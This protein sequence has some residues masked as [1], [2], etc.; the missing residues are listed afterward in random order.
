MFTDTLQPHRELLHEEYVLVQ[1]WKK[2]ATYIRYHNWFS[3][4]L[5]LDRAAVNLPRFIAD[6]RER[7][8]SPDYWQTEPLR[9]VPAPKTQSWTVRPHSGT[10]APTA[11]GATAAPLR[12]L[13]HVSLADQVVATALMLCLADRVETLQGNPRRKI[14]DDSSRK[15]VVSYG[16]RLF[17]DSI[18]GRLRHRWGSTKLYRSYFE[19]YRAFLKRPERIADTHLEKDH[20]HIV[21][22]HAD[23]RQF[24]DRVRPALLAKAIDRI[25]Q[26]G[27]DPVFFD[28]TKSMLN[29]RWD[30][31]DAKE[32]RAYEKL[33]Q[34][35]DFSQVAL[36]QGLVA[37]GFFANVVLLSFDDELK[38]A[39]GTD[40]APGIKLA[41]A[42]RYV[43]DL[44][45]TVVVV[46]PLVSA[47]PESIGAIVTPW[48]RQLLG[49]H[50]PGLQLSAEKT[51]VDAFG[52]DQPPLVR[53]SSRMTRI[54]T[55]VS[56]GFDAL[57][58]D[59]ILNAIHGLIRAQEAL[60]GSEESGWQLT[61]VPDVRNATVARFAAARF[62]FTFRSI[63]PLLDDDD[64]PEKAATEVAL[65][66]PADPLRIRSR[67]ELDEDA[68]SF[69]LGLIRRWV[70]D[71]SNVRLLRVG[72]DIWPDVQ[73]LG[74]ILSLLR[75]F[76]EKGG[77]RKAPRRVAWYLPFRDPP[78]RSNGNRVCSGRR[79]PASRDRSAR[80]PGDAS[81]RGGTTSAIARCYDSV[82]LAP[83]GSAVPGSR[84]SGGRA[85]HSNWPAQ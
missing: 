32:V 11:K 30:S 8:R 63:R 69:A 35:D 38:R 83:A 80:L 7:L 24:Y 55:A 12:P 36:P 68:R 61:P 39:I 21:V 65:T 19:D 18:D 57:G 29:W 31:R 78:R 14:T 4:T 1:A 33:A 25:R 6:L 26:D 70:E 54:Q 72:L 64:G 28:V 16:N 43:D 59:E 51:R 2:T 56:G 62:R 44:R 10:W 34:V 71:P 23:I 3:D 47:T 9:I 60:R 40:I 22:V 45:L 81:Q 73:V 5:A 37:S 75:P 17:C 53:Q 77:R 84:R 79:G 66:R 13:A 82:V 76:T 48:L 15:S 52:A 85:S 41:D 20:K 42:C 74:E 49:D 27:D 46:D 67:R 50:A 58:G